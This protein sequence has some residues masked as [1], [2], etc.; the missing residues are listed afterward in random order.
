MSGLSR[1]LS[2]APDAGGGRRR[3]LAFSRTPGAIS[4][5][6]GL[7]AVAILLVLLRHAV[8]LPAHDRAGV[9]LPVGS[10]DLAVPLLNGWIGVDLFFVLSGFLITHHLLRHEAR[11][12]ALHVGRYLAAR[13]L[14]IAPTYVAVL[15]LAVAGAVPLYSVAS[16]HLGWRVA[17]HLLFL[18]DYLPPDIVVPY[19]SLGVEEKFYL[20]APLLLLT[21][22]R[23]RSSRRRFLFLAGLIFLPTVFRS[24]TAVARPGIADYPSFIPIFRHPFHVTFDGLAV[25]VLCAVLHRDGQCF[26]LLASGRARASAFWLGTG[27]IAGLALSGNLLGE[28]GWYQ[29]T[30]QPLVLSIAFGVVLLS[31]AAGGGPRRVLQS[32]WMLAVARLS[33]PLYL[34]HW[35]LVPLALA[36]T[37]FRAGDPPSAFL[38]YLAVFLTLSFGYAFA[39]HFVV[40]KPFLLLKDWLWSARPDAVPAPVRA[41]VFG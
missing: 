26:A 30:V 10:W 13:A 25:G 29:K 12:R 27:L 36:L 33:Y 20:L 28:I 41:R 24:I 9:H 7:R 3:Y 8:W 31:A 16:G 1:P 15:V 6:D 11:E 23:L 34:I 40:E 4:A 37:G 2:L 5:L 39:L 22:G 19:W 35:T 14:R 32:N 38:G 21:L 18:Q 17:Y